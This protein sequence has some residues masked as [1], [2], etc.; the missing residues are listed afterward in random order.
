V[1]LLQPQSDDRDIVNATAVAV[2]EGALW[3]RGPLR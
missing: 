2:V 1:Q 3:L